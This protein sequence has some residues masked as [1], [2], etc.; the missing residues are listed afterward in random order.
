MSAEK[1]GNRLFTTFTTLAE[2]VCRMKCRIKRRKMRLDGSC[3]ICG[4]GVSLGLRRDGRNLVVCR[5]HGVISAEPGRF[6]RLRA[7]WRAF[8]KRGRE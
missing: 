7:L 8:W 1:V 3:P 5:L 4:R 2:A 6:E